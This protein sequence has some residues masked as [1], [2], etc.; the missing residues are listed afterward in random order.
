MDG[1]SDLPGLYGRAPPSVWAARRQRPAPCCFG[2]RLRC[3]RARRTVVL[4]DHVQHAAAVVVQQPRVEL[5]RGP[6][7]GVARR[8]AALAPLQRRRPDRVGGRGGQHLRRGEGGPDVDRVGLRLAE[9]V[10]GRQRAE[11]PLADVLHVLDDVLRCAKRAKRGGKE[12]HGVKRRL[13]ALALALALAKSTGPGPRRVCLA[14]ARACAPRRVRSR[15][16]ARCLTCSVA[17][18]SGV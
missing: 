13:G 1:V 14:R 10:V 12:G 3:V 7:L 17:S 5:R 15:A 2:R 9:H 4:L 8:R 6:R 16:R 11:A 18:C